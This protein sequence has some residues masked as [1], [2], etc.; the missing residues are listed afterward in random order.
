MCVKF[1]N[2]CFKFVDHHI[3]QWDQTSWVIEL[4]KW[5]GS[6]TQ[7]PPVNKPA[8]ATA[9]REGSDSEGADKDKK[10]RWSLRGAISKKKDD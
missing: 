8:S 2:F 1:C 3:A 10:K 7:P 5:T 4:H 9:S 6:T